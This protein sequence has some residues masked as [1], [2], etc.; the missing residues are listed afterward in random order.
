MEELIPMLEIIRLS[1][2]KRILEIGTS[3]GGTTWH[4]AANSD[5]DAIIT[6]VD[7]PLNFSRI[8]YSSKNL[9]TERPTENELGRYFLET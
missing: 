2:A 1:G 5:D 7:L 9:A 6:T 3:S 4:F 8:D